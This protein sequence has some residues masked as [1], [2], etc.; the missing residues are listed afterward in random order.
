MKPI[1]FIGARGGSKGVRRKNIRILAGKPLIA[2]TIE[3]A[4]KSKFFSSIIVSTEDKEV[5][6]IAKKY[7]ADV[8]FL[9]PKQLATDA[10]SMN[11][12]LLH[13]IQKLKSLKYE[14]D[15]IVVRDCTVP[16]IQINDIKDSISLLKNNKCDIVCGVYKQ[17]HNPYFNMME[18]N[19]KGFL[20]FSKKTKSG[21]VGRQQAPIVYQLTGL[22]AINVKQ[23]L[24]YKKFYMPKNLAYE[25]PYETGLMIDT[26]F[27]FQLAECIAKMKLK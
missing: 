10:A 15:T 6:K 2:H 12:V 19:S 20:R 13:G 26:N 23:F 22:F 25:I 16:F 21:I 4:K 5:S 14:F 7:G 1:C 9:R 11:D 24:K 3:A 27:E 8:P 18:P 17:H